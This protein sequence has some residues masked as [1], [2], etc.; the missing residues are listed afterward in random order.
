M[1]SLRDKNPVESTC[2]RRHAGGPAQIEDE[3]DDEYD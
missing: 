2:T 1:E 3:D